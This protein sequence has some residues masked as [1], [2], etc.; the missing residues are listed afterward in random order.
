MAQAEV[1][2]RQVARE[3]PEEQT[4]ATEPETARRQPQGRLI[5][6]AEAVAVGPLEQLLHLEALAVPAL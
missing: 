1:V 4:L 6:A 2:V 5:V 3:A